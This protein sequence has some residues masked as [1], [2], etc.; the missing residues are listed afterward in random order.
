[1]EAEALTSL[2]LANA[3]FANGFATRRGGVSP[4]P[5]DS[6]NF[7]GGRDAA[8]NVR[9]NVNRFAR[10]VGFTPKELWQSSQVHGARVVRAYEAHT[11]EAEVPP[12]INGVLGEADAVIVR[13]GQTAGV[14]VADCVP[15]LVGDLVSGEAAAIHAGWRGVVAGVIGAALAALGD[16]RAPRAAAI[17]PS[18]GPC[19]FEVGN[20]V[21]RQIAD[22]CGDPQ[23]VAREAPNGK[24][25]VDLRR[26][27]RAQLRAHGLGDGD[28][29][30]VPGCT[31]C[32]A[33]R[34]FSFR[35]DGEKSGRHL[36]VVSGRRPP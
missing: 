11:P 14:R 4:A 20:D 32:D 8:G 34:F 2:V 33:E 13:G 18:I 16:S 21:A 24:A 10:K 12:W 28:I 17:G 15:V 31:R 9:E 7:G 29:E 3:G 25:F 27:V 26:A 36:A 5:Y 1:V 22:A 30:D 6:L 23:V 35:R 19:C